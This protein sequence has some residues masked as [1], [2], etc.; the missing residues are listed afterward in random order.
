M[1][2][3]QSKSYLARIDAFAATRNAV[4]HAESCLESCEDG[5]DIE[6]LSYNIECNFLEIDSKKCEAIAVAVM[7]KRGLL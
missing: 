1:N 2:A 7:R 5:W 6:N 4:T 3:Q